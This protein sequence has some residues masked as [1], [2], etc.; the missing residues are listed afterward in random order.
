M[1]AYT[2]LIENKVMVSTLPKPELCSVCNGEKEIPCGNPDH[3]FIETSGIFGSGDIARIGCPACG[4]SGM[5]TCY[6]CDGNSHK[7]LK[8]FNDSIIGEAE[9]AEQV[10]DEYYVW[11]EDKYLMK[12]NPH[13][14]HPNQPCEVEGLTIK[15]LL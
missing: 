13:K 15:K 7:A 5:T 1:K 2:Q 10:H 14:L 8:K 9:N 4:H 12:H 6:E 3:G 11:I